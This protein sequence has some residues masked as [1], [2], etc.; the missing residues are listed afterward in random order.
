MA[1]PI[2]VQ[3][4][5]RE[6]DGRVIVSAYLALAAIAYGDYVLEVTAVRNGVEVKK[7]VPIRVVR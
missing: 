2:P 3:V 7:F 5:E 4:T 6:R 1:R